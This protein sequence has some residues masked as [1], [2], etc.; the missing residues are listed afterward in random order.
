M[1]KSPAFTFWF[2]WVWFFLNWTYSWK[3]WSCYLRGQQD[4]FVTIW[5]I[6][7][8]S[9]SHISLRTILNTVSSVPRDYFF[10]QSAPIFIAVPLE[11]HNMHFQSHLHSHTIKICLQSSLAITLQT[12]LDVLQELVL[13][14]IL[15]DNGLCNC[16]AYH[17]AI[18]MIAT[19]H[20]RTTKYLI[21]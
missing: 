18:V 1:K 8:Y 21:R 9:I 13:R 16:C 17:K 6:S 11:I 4:T 14:H 12:E 2:D 19:G 3:I 7:L 5:D 15:T 10:Y 20:R